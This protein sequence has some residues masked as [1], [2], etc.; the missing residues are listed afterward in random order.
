MITPASYDFPILQNS[1]YRGV[2]RVTQAAKPVTIDVTTSTF[3]VECG[4]G[5]TAGDRVVISPAT[6][7]S[8]LPCGINS[9]T[10]YY[11]IATGLTTTA[12]K[13]STTS[14]GASLTLALEDVGTF[15]A[16]QPVN[17]TGYTVDADIK[18]LLDGA[19]V[20]T[21]T[22]TITGAT[23]GEF[24]LA[25][26]PATTLAIAAGRYGYDIS[27]TSGGGE[28]YYWLTGVVTVT[29]TYSRS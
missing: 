7:T 13:L 22:P 1:T 27:L 12:F 23:T 8:S 14:G 11:V 20:G 6:T 16:S 29:A 15:F 10:L 5:Y 4:H 26:L 28:R 21:F 18:G 2:F 24:E 17:I 9:T 19:A 3:T 25:M